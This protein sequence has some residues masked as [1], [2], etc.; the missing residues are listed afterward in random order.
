MSIPEMTEPL[1]MELDNATGEKVLA[2]NIGSNQTGQIYKLDL[3]G[4]NPGVYIVRITSG[5]QTVVRKIVIQ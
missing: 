4:L 2:K 1:D 3:T 5:N